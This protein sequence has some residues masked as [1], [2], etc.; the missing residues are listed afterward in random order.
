MTNEEAR[1]RYMLRYRTVHSCWDRHRNTL[2]HLRRAIITQDGVD[3]AF[4]AFQAAVRTLN[5]ARVDLFDTLGEINAAGG[6]LAGGTLEDYRKDVKEG[7]V[8]QR[9]VRLCSRQC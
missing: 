4:A 5:D 7:K 9:T 2:D 8:P 1:S 3:G 6:Y